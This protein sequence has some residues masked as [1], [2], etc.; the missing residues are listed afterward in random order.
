MK[1]SKKLLSIFLAMLMLLGTVSVVGNAALAKDQ[2][3]YDSIDN[4]KLTPEQVACIVLDMLDNDLLAG[5]DTID[6]SII[7]TLRLNK[8]DYIFEDICSL[9]GGFIWAIGSGL[10]GD[11]GKLNFDALAKGDWD[12]PYQR[13]DGNLTILYQLLQFIADN[14]GTLSKVAYGIG[15]DNGLSLGLIGSFLS[16]GDIEDVLADLPGFLTRMVYD[17]LITDYTS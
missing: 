16:L 9:R 7:G 14:A 10:L 6:L 13:S 3:A 2:V 4:A 5:M 15:T 1:Q 17:K 8:V 11:V 12:K